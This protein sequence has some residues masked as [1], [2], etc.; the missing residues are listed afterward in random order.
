MEYLYD[1]YGIKRKTSVL[2]A[3]NQLAKLKKES[4]SNPWPVI[5]KC[6][7]IWEKTHPTKYDSYLM[8]LDDIKD[9]RKVT[10]V[11]NKQFTGVSKAGNGQMTSYVADMPKQVMYMIRAIYDSDEL[12][13]NKE[14]WQAF[15]RKFPQYMIRQAV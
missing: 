15:C 14:F 4:G 7:T 5:E 8:Y 11:G 12:P 1:Q 6:F 9:T 2:S 3:A 10:N 13:M